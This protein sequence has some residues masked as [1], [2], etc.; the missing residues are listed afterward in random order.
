MKTYDLVII[1][2]GSAMNIVEPYLNQKPRARIAVID[3][4]PPGGICLNKGCVPTKLLVYPAE[5]IRMLDNAALLGLE[6]QIRRVDFQ[7]IMERMRATVQADVEAIRKGLHSADNIDYYPVAARFIGPGRLQAGKTEL[8]GRQ[9]ILCLGSRPHIPAIKG[10]DG[11]DHHTSDSILNLRRL[12]ARIAIVGGGYIAAEYGHFFAA[13]GSRVTIIGRNPRFLPEEEPEI[14]EL[15]QKEMSRHMTLMTG[16]EV[17]AVATASAGEKQIYYTDRRTGAQGRLAADEILVA[18][19]RA[20]TSD[21][22]EPQRAGIQTD[23]NG[24]IVVDAHLRTSVEN[25]WAL[26]DAIG[27][28][29]FKHVANYESKVLYYNAVLNENIRTDYHA[30]PHAVFCYPEVAAVGL[31]E[32]MALREPGADNLLIGFQRF[33][34]TTKG[35]AMAADGYFVKTLVEKHTGRILGAHIV[36]PQ[37]SILIQE[38]VTLMYSESPTAFPITAGMHIHPSLSE[39]VERAFMSLVPPA[40]YHAAQAAGRL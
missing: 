4:D 34:D 10:L 3:K 7:K 21:L 18:A 9:I 30:V 15:V 22:L 24:W 5:L 8:T 39:V 6:V 37:A 25:I 11:V 12:P 14:S 33:R 35:D 31:T 40:Q 1:G 20:A 2:T 23:D 28:H 17:T 36:G 38:V 29:Q 32:Q 13:M 26:G 16:H 19:G 27:K